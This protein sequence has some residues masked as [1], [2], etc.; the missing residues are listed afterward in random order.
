MIMPFLEVNGLPPSHVVEVEYAGLTTAADRGKKLGKAR[1]GE[2][3]LYREFLGLHAHAP[4]LSGSRP[5]DHAQVLSLP[6]SMNA[7]TSS[8]GNGKMMV[9]FFSV[10][11]SVSV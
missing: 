2:R 6:F 9:E 11:I 10:A 3:P 1:F 7:P 8:T 4:F 5:L